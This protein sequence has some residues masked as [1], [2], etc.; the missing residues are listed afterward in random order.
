MLQ[1]GKRGDSG[2][3]PA[4]VKTFFGR[5]KSLEQYITCRFEFNFD[6]KL[7]S[8]LFKL[9]LVWEWSRCT[10][11]CANRCPCATP[12]PRRT[13]RRRRNSAGVS[14]RYRA[15]SAFIAMSCL[16]CFISFWNL[17]TWVFASAMSCSYGPH[18][19]LRYLS[20][21]WPLLYSSC[22][23]YSPLVKFCG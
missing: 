4:E 17:V 8:I 14:T 16:R 6:L 21:S 11:K 20:S 19:S 1:T 23:Q 15:P 3:I 9:K 22:R 18:A 12:S 7:N 10:L 13:S 5:I 2:S